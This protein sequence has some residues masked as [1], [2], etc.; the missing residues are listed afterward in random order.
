MKLQACKFVRERPKVKLK[1]QVKWEFGFANVTMFGAYDAAWI[2]DEA[3][4]KVADL[5][6]Y[7]L[8]DGL[9]GYLAT[10]E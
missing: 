5:W 9:P 4:N 7:H 8:L 1:S 10:N 6:D 2:I 3:G